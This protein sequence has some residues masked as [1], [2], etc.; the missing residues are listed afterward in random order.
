MTT[1]EDVK[2]QVSEVLKSLGV[3]P[4]KNQSDVEAE[5]AEWIRQVRTLDDRRKKTWVANSTEFNKS[6]DLCER[7]RNQLV[8][9]EQ[10]RARISA[11]RRTAEHSLQAGAQQVSWRLYRTAPAVIDVARESMNEELIKLRKQRIDFRHERTDRQDVY[12]NEVLKTF[13]DRVALNARVKAMGEAM[14]Q[15]EEL[16]TTVATEA[17]AIIEINKIKAA[18]PELGELVAEGSSK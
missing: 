5:R 4:I 18:L 7:L 8:A 14:H 1:M 2:S 9:A 15:F 10:E 16:K 6:N 11:E 13:S 12:G 3:L 17:E